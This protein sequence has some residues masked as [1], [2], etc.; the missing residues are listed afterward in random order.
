MRICKMLILTLTWIIICCIQLTMVPCESLL[1]FPPGLQL[2]EHLLKQ[3][4]IL[5]VL[6]PAY[7]HVG[8]YMSMCTRGYVYMKIQ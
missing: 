8:M 1:L 2:G 5:E 4:S 3:L 7:V 6:S